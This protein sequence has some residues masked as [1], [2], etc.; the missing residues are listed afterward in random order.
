MSGAS[1]LIIVVKVPPH[2]PGLGSA[3]PHNHIAYI[4]ANPDIKVWGT[5]REDVLDKMKK[6]MI[7]KII[8]QR[9]SIELVNELIVEDTHNG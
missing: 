8:K 2:V 7:S 6:H 9:E 1:L 4:A 5:S 3:N